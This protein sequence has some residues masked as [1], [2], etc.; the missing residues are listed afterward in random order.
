M[1][2]MDSNGTIHNYV[3]NITFYWIW[4][5]VLTPCSTATLDTSTGTLGFTWHELE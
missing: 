4:S 2:A 1:T 5:I 3:N